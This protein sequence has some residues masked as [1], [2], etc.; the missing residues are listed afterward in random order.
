MRHHV[1]GELSWSCENNANMILEAAI[2][3]V[4][5]TNENYFSD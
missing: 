5:T 2:T 3:L 4:F 1:R